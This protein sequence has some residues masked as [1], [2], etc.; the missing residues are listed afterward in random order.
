MGLQIETITSSPLDNNVIL[1]HE[2]QSHH[3]ILVDPSFD[4]IAVL[5]RIHEKKWIV[6]TI[7]V[8]HGHFDHY[9]GLPFL[10]ANLDP[11][12]HI[13]L[14]PLD[15]PLWREGGGAKEF[16]VPIEIPPDPDL[17]LAHGQVLPFGDSTIEVRHT[18]GHSP[19]SVTFY[20]P[21]LKTAL[22]GDLI[23]RQGIGRT[24]LNGGNFD[25]LCESIRDQIYTL[26]PD[27][28]LILGHGLNTTVADE[29]H[30]NPYVR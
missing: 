10:L 14:H 29:I 1:I 26:P 23:F 28:V 12:P 21:S 16:R 17:M 27:T 18:P 3:A 13:G 9:I 15:L 6:D 11:R 30:S 8:T 22:T 7:L 2:D 5:N 24:D 19:G 4:P 25:Q 20:L